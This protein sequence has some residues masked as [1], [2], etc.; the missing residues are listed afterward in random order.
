VLCFHQYLLPTT[1]ALR[2][3]HTSILLFFTELPQEDTPSSHWF[4]AKSKSKL[5]YDRR[6]VGQS[7][8]VSGTH[9]GPATIFLNIFR[10]WW[11]VDVRCPLWREVG[12][13]V[14]SWCFTSAAQ[15][16]S[17]LSPAGLITTFHCF[18]FWDSPN[19]EGQV[20]AF[21]SPKNRVAQLYPQHLVCL[22]HL[23]IIAW[24]I[25]SS[26]M[27]NTYIRPLLVQ[28]RCRRLCLTKGSSGCNTSLITWSVIH[29]TTS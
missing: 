22:I 20:L 29:L 21:I 8:S 10:H 26:Y 4:G 13:A 17:G 18:S 12:L 16:F 3:C 7:V 24:Y 11:F 23:H 19:L 2:Q 1:Q 14:F 27:H 28:A 15:T 6:A 5:Y 9:L 25:Y